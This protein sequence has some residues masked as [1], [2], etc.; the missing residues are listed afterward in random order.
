[1]KNAR[2]LFLLFVLM[3]IVVNSQT[4]DLSTIR[5]WQVGIGLGELPIGGSFKPS[6]NFGYHINTKLYVGWIYQFKDK[7]S[8]DDSSFN[9]DATELNGLT[10]SSEKVGQRFLLQMRY[11]PFKKGPYI[12]TGYVFNDTDKETMVFDSRARTING[13]NYNG[14]ISIDQTRPRGGGFALGI[15]YQYDFKNGISLNTEWTPAWFTGF[16]QPKYEFKGD[17]G[18]SASTQ[19]YLREKMDEDFRSNVTNLFKVFHFGASYRF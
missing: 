5:H 15:G 9:A 19:N 3:T 17:A 7:I 2:F 13:E 14:S 6:I 11:T 10:D 18:L 4:K 16:A 8:R 12:S 1:M